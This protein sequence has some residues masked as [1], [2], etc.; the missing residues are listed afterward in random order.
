MK[1]IKFR[2]LLDLIKLHMTKE[3]TCEMGVLVAAIL[4]NH[5]LLQDLLLL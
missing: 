1:Q 4:R 5:I 2:I 3:K